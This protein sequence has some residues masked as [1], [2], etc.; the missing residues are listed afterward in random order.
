MT[1][2]AELTKV[3]VITETHF[4]KEMLNHFGEQGIKGFTCVNCWG[5]RAS[6]GV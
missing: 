1:T 5:A 3:I 4:E 6:P 2:T